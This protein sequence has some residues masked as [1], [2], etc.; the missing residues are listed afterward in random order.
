MHFDEQLIL[1][2]PEVTYGVDP[3]PTGAA[4]AIQTRDFTLT[5]LMGDTKT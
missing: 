1:I 4:N 5:P 3:T 2:K